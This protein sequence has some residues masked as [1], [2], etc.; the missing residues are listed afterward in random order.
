[1]RIFYI[2][3]YFHKNDK[4]HNN[5]LYAKH[6]EMVS[7]VLIINGLIVILSYLKISNYL[8]MGRYSII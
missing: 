7:Q 4:K 1:M 3:K 5:S 8:P 2:S 6:R